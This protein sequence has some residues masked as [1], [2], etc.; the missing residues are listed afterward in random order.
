[1]T[2]PYLFAKDRSGTSGRMGA[3][4][5]HA[6]A[7][8]TAAALGTDAYVILS[9]AWSRR[10]PARS[11]MAAAITNALF[12]SRPTGM[13]RSRRTRSA[14]RLLAIGMAGALAID[15]Y[16]R[17]T[18]AGAYVLDDLLVSLAVAVIALAA[19]QRTTYGGW[20]GIPS[21]AENACREARVR[22]SHRRSARLW[23]QAI[24]PR[25]VRA[26][27]EPSPDGR[28]PPIHSTEIRSTRRTASGARRT[29]SCGPEEHVAWCR[30]H[31][32]RKQASSGIG[33]KVTRGDGCP[34]DLPPNGDTI[35]DLKG[36]GQRQRYLGVSNCDGQ[37]IVHLCHHEV[38]ASE[39]VPDLLDRSRV[40]SDPPP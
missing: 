3:W 15:A 28:A 34:Y 27:M 22:P 10:T 11:T 40:G 36:H 25:C 5:R 24:G 23:S 17:R 33:I 29:G 9:V 37:T 2:T 26:V 4:L 20:D 38:A 6:L 21:S 16:V 13:D 31:S 32:R 30:P 14:R 8:V 12:P 39:H 7:A 19:V 1:M 18:D 35:S